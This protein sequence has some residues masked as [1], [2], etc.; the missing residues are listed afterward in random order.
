MTQYAKDQTRRILKTE[1]AAY[2]QNAIDF[3]RRSSAAP[4][5]G[6]LQPTAYT[7]FY[8]TTTNEGLEKYAELKAEGWTLLDN[9]LHLMA[10][11]GKALSLVCKCPESVFETYIPI[12]AANAEKAYV[13]E[14]EAHNRQAQKLQERAKEIQLEFDRREEERKA[15]LMAEITKEFDQKAR[16]QFV[17]AASNGLH[18]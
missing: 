9:T 5:E 16:A 15:L 18:H 1:Q 2:V 7:T 14:V 11:P 17:P 10:V 6:S 3:A 12:I 4:H 13:A 8:V